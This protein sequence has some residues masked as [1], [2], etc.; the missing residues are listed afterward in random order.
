MV[1]KSLDTLFSVIPNLKQKN[2]E[3]LNNYPDIVDIYI[4]PECLWSKR[5]LKLLDVINITYNKI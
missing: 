3:K 4:L 5:S 1:L 2:I